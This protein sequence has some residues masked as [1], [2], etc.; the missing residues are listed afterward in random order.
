MRQFD[1]PVSEF[2]YTLKNAG[3]RPVAFTCEGRLYQLTSIY[4]ETDLLPCYKRCKLQSGTYALVS[5][6]YT[7]QSFLEVVYQCSYC[8]HMTI[9]VFEIENAR[10][11]SDREKMF[12]SALINDVMLKRSQESP[13]EYTKRKKTDIWED[14]KKKINN[15]TINLIFYKIILKRFV[16]QEYLSESKIYIK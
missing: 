5:P 9:R 16:T 12:L 10:K 1:A 2:R 13:E 15:K 7:G 4:G 8:D 11:Y 6:R 14:K 3:D